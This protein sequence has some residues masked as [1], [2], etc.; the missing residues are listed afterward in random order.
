MRGLEVEH[1]ASSH[2][3]LIED[4]STKGGDGRDGWVAGIWICLTNGGNR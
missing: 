2:V 3:L 1:A 4:I